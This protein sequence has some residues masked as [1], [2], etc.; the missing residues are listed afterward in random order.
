MCGDV[1]PFEGEFPCFVAGMTVT[2]S[3]GTDTPEAATCGCCWDGEKT[4]TDVPAFGALDGEFWIDTEIPGIAPWER[5]AT[6]SDADD[7]LPG[8]V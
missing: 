3:W 1:G 8:C 5:G 4:L 7:T 6:R 2:R